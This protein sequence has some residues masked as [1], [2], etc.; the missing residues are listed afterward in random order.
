MEGCGRSKEEMQETVLDLRGT[1]EGIGRGAE[2]G[3]VV[4][5]SGVGGE[6]VPERIGMRG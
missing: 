6:G 4:V 1:A 3:A 2:G 5:R